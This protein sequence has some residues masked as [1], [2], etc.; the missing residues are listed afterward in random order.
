MVFQISI[1]KVTDIKSPLTIVI[2][3][4][5]V[6]CFMQEPYHLLLIFMVWE[7]VACTAADAWRVC[8]QQRLPLGGQKLEVKEWET[9]AHLS[10]LVWGVTS[11]MCRRDH[12]QWTA[13]GQAPKR[14]LV[15]IFY[16]WRKWGVEEAV[17]NELINHM[18]P[19]SVIQK[20]NYEKTLSTN[21][22]S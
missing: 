2:K 17:L 19:E 11:N 4:I 13:S 22:Y 6:S 21:G 1:K 16:T 7:A 15:A 18:K 9:T 5:K 10:C 12:L 20:A 3:C 8:K 14:R